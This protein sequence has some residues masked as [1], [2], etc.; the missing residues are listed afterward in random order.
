MSNTNKPT[1]PP[2]AKLIKAWAANSSLPIQCK[3]RD[4]KWYDEPYPIWNIDSEYRIKPEENEP[5]KPKEGER[6]YFI[7]MTGCVYGRCWG[8][9]E[10]DNDCYSFGNCFHTREEAEAAAER[11]KAAL[12]GDVVSKV[13]HEHYV[14]QCKIS[15]KQSH[16]LECELYDR[17]TALE[18]ENKTLRHDLKKYQKRLEIIATN[19]LS[20]LKIPAP[21][22]E[23][24][25]LDGK[26]LTDIEKEAVR[27]FRAGIPFAEAE[28]GTWR[29]LSPVEDALIKALRDVSITHVPDYNTSVLS[30][31][32]D[33]KSKTSCS[34]YPIAF[35]TS[36]TSTIDEAII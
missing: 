13:E 5:W 4:G 16:D 27:K 29:A 1:P 10:T 15:T 14:E 9:S 24:F 12:K 8:N 2:H 28:C 32:G 35:I 19:G 11:V 30:Y 25:Q 22:D 34:C 31:P 6:F 3:G 23:N 36:S 33:D 7:G 26:P 17:I 20:E 21:S 18:R